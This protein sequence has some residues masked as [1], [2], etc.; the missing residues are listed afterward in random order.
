MIAAMVNRTFSSSMEVGVR[1]EAEEMA[2]GLRRHCCSAYLTFVSLKAKRQ[3]QL[4]RPQPT[5]PQQQQSRDGSSDGIYQHSSYGR[6][7]D[8]GDAIQQQ[9][10]QQQCFGLPRVVPHT[11]EQQRIY[12]Q[13][14]SRRQQRLAARQA[15]KDDPHKAALLKA[16][17]LRPVTHRYERSIGGGSSQEGHLRCHCCLFITGV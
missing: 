11:S 7:Q 2:T 16:C 6:Q 3:A 12:A 9:Q 14:E 15:A 8:S 10:Q 17:R 1:V 4:P 13:A 5:L